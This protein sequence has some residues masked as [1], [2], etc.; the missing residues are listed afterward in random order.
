MPEAKNFYMLKAAP[1]PPLPP[2]RQP[3]S[4]RRQ[5]VTQI[6]GVVR[7]T[8]WL[9]QVCSIDGRRGEK[10]AVGEGGEK[11]RGGLLGVGGELGGEG[12]W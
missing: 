3:C 4:I 2:S 10:Q 11:G 1:S 7:R 8:P 9:S 5:E 6:R 12:G